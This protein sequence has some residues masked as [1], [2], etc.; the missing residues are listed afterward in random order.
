MKGRVGIRPGRS[1]EW[2]KSF[3]DGKI[4]ADE[5]KENFRMSQ[6]SFIVLCGELNA[7][8][9]RNDTR[10]RKAVSVETQVAVTLYYLADEGRIRLQMLF[11]LEN[12]R[13]QLL[14]VE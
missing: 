5:W 2:W 14:F 10:F 11:V 7:Y 3:L 8:I 12:P 13:L 9:N 6:E 1:N 4:V